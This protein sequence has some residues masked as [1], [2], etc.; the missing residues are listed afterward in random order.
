MSFIITDTNEGGGLEDALSRKEIVFVAGSPSTVSRSSAVARNVAAR[1][2]GLGHT[3]CW[4]D[5]RD[6]DPGDVFFSRSDAPAVKRFVESVRGAA[7]V[8][9]STPVYKATYAGALKALVDLIPSDALA[10]KPALGIGTTPLDGHGGEFAR[11]FDALFS[12]FKA[13]PLGTL[14]VLDGEVTVGEGGSALAACAEGRLA[15]VL[16]ELSRALGAGEL[17]ARSLP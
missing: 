10:G 3:T 6:F 1:L 5:V 11:S 17:E 15:I 14:L 4:L 13:R 9:F 8:V 12:F 16:R 7:A 2:E